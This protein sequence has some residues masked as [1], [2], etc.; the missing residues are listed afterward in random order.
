MKQLFMIHGRSFKPE[1][2][3]LELLWREALAA[4]LERDFGSAVADQFRNIKSEFIYY[5]DLSNEFLWS[6]G[7]EYDPREDADSR[8]VTLQE[9]KSF[10]KSDF[11]KA[12][13]RQRTGVFR[14]LAEGIADAIAWPANIFGVADNLVSAVAPDMEHYWNED[15]AYGSEVRWRLTEPLARVFAAGDD[16]M[17]ISH[18]L[19]TMIAYDV[20]WKFSHYGEYRNI[21]SH[22]LCRWVTLGSPLGNLTVKSRL[23]GAG[24]RGDRQFP[25]NIE[26]WQNFAAEDDYISQDQTIADDFSAMRL[27]PGKTRIEDKH[28]YNLAIRNGKPNQHHG[29]GYLV[30]PQVSKV[31]NDWM[32]SD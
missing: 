3:D 7:M 27:A 9:L 8:Q 16:V 1:S 18:S 21:R 17:L 26:R 2:G 25:Q 23:K 14:G 29:A 32:K 12:K 4:G 20:L 31:L 5:G 11:T 6:R 10:R 28:I 13:Y 19:G 15:T 24:V 22:R 30:H